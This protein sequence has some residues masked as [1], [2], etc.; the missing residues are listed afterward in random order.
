MQYRYTVKVWF[1]DGTHEEFLNVVDSEVDKSG[2]MY[3]IWYD[4]TM[5]TEEH[6]R[7]VVGIPMTQIFK[8]KKIFEKPE[9]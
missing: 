2:W 9:E 5:V 8:I 6:C 4:A 3:N 1:A 7:V